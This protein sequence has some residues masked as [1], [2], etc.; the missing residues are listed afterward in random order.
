MTYP[1]VIKNNFHFFQQI[2]AV[3]FLVVCIVILK[4]FLQRKKNMGSLLQ[5][6]L[7][8]SWSYFIWR[9]SVHENHLFITV[10]TALCLAVIY[11][12]RYNTRQYLWL[13]LIG[14]SHFIVFFGFPIREG[15]IL[16]HSSLKVIGG[17]PLTVL[18]SLFHILIYLVY[19]KRFMKFQ[20]RSLK[21]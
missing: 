11:T 14:L 20:Y 1:E 9:T 19:L 6:S 12:N 17:I 4:C 7:M 18:L 16:L 15:S 3:I 8:I 10:L 5:T 13:C 21:S 2:S